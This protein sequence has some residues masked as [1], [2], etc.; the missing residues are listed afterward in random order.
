M[1]QKRWIKDECICGEKT[2]D[3][4]RERSRN[5]KSILLSIHICLD[6]FDPRYVCINWL[7]F[8]GAHPAAATNSNNQTIYHSKTSQMR[9]NEPKHPLFCFPI[10]TS[11]TALYYNFIC[12]WIYVAKLNFVRFSSVDG[13]SFHSHV[14]NF[15]WLNS[16]ELNYRMIKRNFIMF[17]PLCDISKG[18]FM[19]THTYTVIGVNEHHQTE[20]TKY[21]LFPVL[22]LSLYLYDNQTGGHFP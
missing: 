3:R 12:I 5:I 2:R 9:N 14:F 4:E 11:H 21:S 1:W 22:S 8:S 6:H 18:A 20:N 16:H 15:G 19:F 13:L 7:K 17:A 10:G